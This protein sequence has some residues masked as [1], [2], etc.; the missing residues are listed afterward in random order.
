MQNLVDSSVFGALGGKKSQNQ[1]APGGIR[2]SGAVAKRD[3]AQ[4]S[5]SSS[6]SLSTPN[7]AI[8]VPGKGK[9][10]GKQPQQT[11]A[12][13]EDWPFRDFLQSGS[14]SSPPISPLLSPVSS[15]STTTSKYVDAPVDERDEIIEALTSTLENE[16]YSKTKAR[17]GLNEDYLEELDTIAPSILQEKFHDKITAISTKFFP[18]SITWKILS[19]QLAPRIKNLKNMSYFP[20]GVKLPCTPET[21]D[22]VQQHPDMTSSLFVE[23]IISN[24]LAYRMGDAP[25]FQAEGLLGIDLGIFH[26]HCKAIYPGG[27]QGAEWTA[28]TLQ[29]IEKMLQVSNEA[30]FKQKKISDIKTVEQ[31]NQTRKF[32]K[33]WDTLQEMAQDLVSE[34]FKLSIQWHSKPLSF[35][36]HGMSWFSHR[37]IQKCSKILGY[38][39]DDESTILNWEER[40]YGQEKNV[41]AVISPMFFREEW[42]G[43][44]KAQSRVRVWK[45]PRLLVTGTPRLGIT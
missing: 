3:S 40:F 45:E 24:T 1:K 9:G 12:E 7:V 39:L 25:V 43:L 30:D 22:A 36:Q 14:E 13:E 8:E 38:N 28:L 34:A 37:T 11:I 19:S 5:P 33:E 44:G 26:Y 18:K 42:D 41:I 32:T 4:E 6:K 29:M 16:L 23:G 17:W 2:R 35:G 10:K 20:D 31:S 27:P 21:W 15:P